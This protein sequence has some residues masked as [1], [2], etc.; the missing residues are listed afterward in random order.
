MEM[1]EREKE[2]SASGGSVSS[3]RCGSDPSINDIE[4][5]FAEEA[6]G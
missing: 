3:E 6:S 4:D 1:R 5:L 2:E